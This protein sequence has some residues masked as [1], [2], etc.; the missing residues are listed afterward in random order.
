MERAI[1]VGMQTGYIK[2]PKEFILTGD[3]VNRLKP[4][5]LTILV[6]GSQGEPLAALSRIANGNHRQLKAM[7]GDTVIFSSS[8]IPGNQEGVNR[9]INK[10]FRLDVEVITHGPLAD[11]HTSG[12]G[13]QSDLKL[14]LSLIKPKMFIPIHGEHRMLKHHSE[15]ALDCGVSEDNILIMDNGDVA[16]ITKDSIR[17]A[18]KVTSGEVYIDGTGIGDIGSQVIRERKLLSEEGLFAVVLSINSETKKMVNDPTIISRGF[19]Y[20]KGNEEITSSLAN[21]AKKVVQTELNKK[22]INELNIKQAVIDQLTQRIFELTQRK[23]LIIPILVDLNK[24]KTE[25]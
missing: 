12:H 20:M 17:L 3:M 11:T 8:P 18:G 5:E 22:V 9:T 1:E 24:N 15:L 19:I 16:A 4:N 6:T 7:A 10:L 2:A 13:G 21:E 25:A 14:V 23:P